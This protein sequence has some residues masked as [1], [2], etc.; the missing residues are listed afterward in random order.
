MT[1]SLGSRRGQLRSVVTW[2][3]TRDPLAR[4]PAQGSEDVIVEPADSVSVDDYRAMYRRVGEPWL[5]WE[6]LL[7]PDA[8]TR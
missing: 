4:E 2:L 6:R 5:W 1:A 3:E 8:A 7:M